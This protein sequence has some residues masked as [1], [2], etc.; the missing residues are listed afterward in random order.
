MRSVTN[1]TNRRVTRIVI[2]WYTMYVNIVIG[3]SEKR[4]RSGEKVFDPVVSGRAC[5]VARGAPAHPQSSTDPATINCHYNKVD[6]V[7]I[8]AG[9]VIK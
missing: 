5:R 3:V 1:G 7:Q 6:S 2:I 4:V 8:S 9:N